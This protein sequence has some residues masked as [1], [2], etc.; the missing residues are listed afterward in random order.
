MRFKYECEVMSLRTQN[1]ELHFIGKTVTEPLLQERSGV[2][3]RAYLVEIVIRQSNGKTLVGRRRH[4]SEVQ[5]RSP[6]SEYKCED[7]EDISSTY[8]HENR[9]VYNE[10]STTREEN[11]GNCTLGLQPLNI[12][13]M[14]RN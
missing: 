10:M 1:W 8:S 4:K 11:S 2:W 3:F 5:G 14:R 9:W 7:C 12:G 6:G 13:V